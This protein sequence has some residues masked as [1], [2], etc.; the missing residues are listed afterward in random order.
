[1]YEVHNDKQYW[2]SDAELLVV[3][4]DSTREERLSLIPMIMT[5]HAM[6]ATDTLNTRMKERAHTWMYIEF[7]G[8]R[9]LRQTRM[10]KE[11][12]NE[13]PEK[14][15]RTFNCQRYRSTSIVL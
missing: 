15:N 2:W 13:E 10:W 12:K 3:S 5:V 11:E 1:M 9:Y 8:N 4:R 14:S 7:T 6:H